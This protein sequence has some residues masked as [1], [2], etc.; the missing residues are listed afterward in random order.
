MLA[1]FAT[2]CN[3]FVPR[4]TSCHYRRGRITC[5]TEVWMEYSVERVIPFS[6]D[7]VWWVLADLRHFARRDPFHSDF[8][9]LP[10]PI[11]GIGAQFTLQHR[12][13][14]IFPFPKDT[15]RCRVTAWDPECRIVL[16]ET[17][18]RAYRSHVQK[19][20]LEPVVTGTLVRFSVRYSG[21]PW[22][23]FPWRLWVAALVRR[24]MSQKLVDLER[25]CAE[26][27]PLFIF[28]LNYL[29]PE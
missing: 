6:A 25:D 5:P 10:G 7:L 24:R 13:W 17:N 19:F 29:A 28:W 15:V 20:T 18:S 22:L 3:S 26:R 4:G 8:E 27:H 23:L 16:T 11:H 12:Y 21:I 2:V 14:P 9:W 1:L